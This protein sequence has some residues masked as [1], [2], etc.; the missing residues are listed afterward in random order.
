MWFTAVKLTLRIKGLQHAGAPCLVLQIATMQST[1]QYHHFYTSQVIFW[2]H[3][4]II[5]VW[6]RQLDKFALIGLLGQ[7]KWEPCII[8]NGVYRISN[9]SSVDKAWHF[10]CYGSWNTQQLS[11]TYNVNARES[12]RMAAQQ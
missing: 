6:A 10:K 5:W 7:E 1:Y 2:S 3:Y 8:H 12:A 11:G 9:C 4:H